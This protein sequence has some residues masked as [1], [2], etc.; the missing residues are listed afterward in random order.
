[1]ITTISPLV[2]GDTLKRSWFV[3][4]LHAISSVAG[5]IV[6][7]GVLAGVGYLIVG[8]WPWVLRTAI[9]ATTA[10]VLTLREVGVLPVPLPMNYNSVPQHWWRKYGPVQG[11]IAYGFGLGL[12]VTT[13][14]PYA[15]F[16]IALSW[17]FLSGNPLYG[18]L[19]GIVY[20][21]VRAAPV[22]AASGHIARQPDSARVHEDAKA[23][24][25]R[26]LACRAMTFPINAVAD[27]IFVAS[28]SL[29]VAA[30][31]WG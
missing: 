1:M 14:I 21:G 7:F 25:D 23:I 26:I 24:A 10:F 17:A 6:T 5:G 20:G 29:A 11:A 27:M 16:Y 12:G 18:I 22:L 4:A 30:A 19:A 15:S 28:A 13:I 8:G 9:A 3:L 31:L 2:Q